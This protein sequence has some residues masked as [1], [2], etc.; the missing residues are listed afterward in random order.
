MRYWLESCHVV[1]SHASLIWEGSRFE[2][3]ERTRYAPISH[4]EEDETKRWEFTVPFGSRIDKWPER[5]LVKLAMSTVWIDSGYKGTTYYQD[6]RN[7][8][9]HK[10]SNIGYRG[11]LLVV[12]ITL[13]FTLTTPKFIPMQVPVV[14]LRPSIKQKLSKPTKGSSGRGREN[15]EEGMSKGEED[16]YMSTVR[17]GFIA[18][19]P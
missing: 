18:N 14:P 13:G 10:A 16:K 8:T 19:S 3:H 1:S 5:P 15:R 17:R 4:E 9:W 11:K 7:G 12:K 6:A 2:G